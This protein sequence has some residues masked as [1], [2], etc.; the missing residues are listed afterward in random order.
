MQFLSFECSGSTITE[1]DPMFKKIVVP[2]DGSEP[3]DA[4]VALALQIAKEDQGEV[5]F[6]HAVELNKIVALA[7]P[8]PIDPSIAID[9]ACQVGKEL[10]DKMKSRANQAGVRS[11]TE[12]PEDAC[13]GSVLEIARQRKADLIVVGS[14][15]RSGIPR[16]LLGSVAEGILRRSPIPVL[17]CHAPPGEQHEPELAKAAKAAEQTVI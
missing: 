1:E 16:A 6:V 2:V 8:A 15:G 17:V 10:L 14:H 13:V 3:S 4:A 11:S 7:G 12:L 5:I 9:A